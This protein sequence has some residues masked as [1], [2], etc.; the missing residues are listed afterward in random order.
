MKKTAFIIIALLLAFGCSD[1]KHEVPKEDNPLFSTSRAISLNQLGE[2]INLEKI[3][4]YNPTKVIKKDSLLIVLDLN[5]LN[6]ISIYQENG[7]LL[8][9]YLPTGM[10]ADRGL[11]ILTM[12]LDDKGI[13]SAYDFGNDRLV[14]FDLNHFGQPEFGPKFIDM[15]KDKKHLCVA[16]SGTTIISTGMFDDGRYGLMNNNNEEYFLSYPEIPSYRTIN[17]TLRSALFASNIIKIKPDGT[18]FVCANMQSGII[19]FCSLIPCTNITRVAELN[20]YS[21]K[22][23]VKNMRRTPVA[24]STDNLFGFC[25]IEVTDEYI[26]ALYSGRS[27]RKYKDQIVYGERI[28]VFD[29]EGNHVHTYLLRNPFTSISFNKEENAIY[30]L[31]NNPNSVLIKYTLD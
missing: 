4:I 19:D 7:K 26:Y 16:K 1:E 6:K 11:Y 15:P 20:L 29:W 27:Y 25:D 2:T 17:D 10:G 22:A 31:T 24:Y 21:P 9:S 12:T 30:G 13:L 5:G 3:G 18:K 28:V 23:T 8:G 14:E